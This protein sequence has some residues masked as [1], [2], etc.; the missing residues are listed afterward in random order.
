MQRFN[1]LSVSLDKHR[2]EIKA[3]GL[4]SRVWLCPGMFNDKVLKPF[5]HEV[6]KN[7][8]F[9]GVDISKKT[10]DLEVL[11]H[12]GD[13]QKK[14]ELGNDEKSLAVFFDELTKEDPSFD[15]K[16]TMVCLEHTGIYANVLLGFLATVKT[17]ICIEMALQI[18]NSQGMVRGK[19]DQIDAHRIAQYVFKNQREVRLWSPTRPQVQKL[20]ALLTLRER[21]VRI[22][23]QL[24]VPLNEGDGFIEGSIQ[25]ELR[26]C[27][28]ASIK[29]VQKDIEKV[30]RD[31]AGL[32][33]QDATLKKQFDLLTSVTG[34][35]PIIAYNMIVTTNE[36]RSITEAKKYACY[37]GVAPFPNESGTSVNS[38]PRVSKLAN[39]DIKKLLYLGATSAI[40]HC[41]ELKTYYERKVAEGKK[42]M[43]VVNAVRNKLISRAFACI[44]DQ[45]PY[46][47]TYKHS[48][49]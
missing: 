3:R 4:L 38:R 19:S 46:E 47:K 25:K 23:N 5:K 37:A 2:I 40:Q 7:M 31:I 41:E 33:R 9:I 48:L 42:K 29:A 35:G 27:S 28:K 21:L 34:I 39:M 26:A 30:G 15:W 24:E 6:M 8:H 45:R 12:S 22:G 36:F 10:L 32:I 17:N 18:K 49:A 14:S 11:D 43:S 20:K 1:P 44:R 16:T 13:I